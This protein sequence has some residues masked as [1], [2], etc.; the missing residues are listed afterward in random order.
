[1]NG[2]NAFILTPTYVNFPVHWGACLATFLDELEALRHHL[3][4]HDMYDGVEYD[5]KEM[6]NAITLGRTIIET[7][8]ED[9]GDW[10]GFWEFL[11][12]HMR[13]WWC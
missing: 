8:G 12:D 3:E 13:R 5:V 11:A 9:E 10:H 6:A 2:A 1:M 7:G 4:T